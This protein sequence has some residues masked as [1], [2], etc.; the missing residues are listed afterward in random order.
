VR[1]EI[2]NPSP[3]KGATVGHQSTVESCGAASWI[4]MARGER[5]LLDAD[6]TSWLCDAIRSA[7]ATEPLAIVLT[8][9]GTTF[10]G[11]ADGPHLRETG[12]AKPFA[13]AAVELFE[14][15]D[16]IPTPVIAA[17]NGDALAGGFALA[18][19]ADIVVA[20][21]SARLGTIEASL[22]TWPMI[23]QAPALARVPA[24]AAVTNILTGVPFTALEAASLGVVDRVIE[25]AGLSAAVDGY[26]ELLAPGSTAAR[27]GRPLMRRTLN[28]NLGQS[29]RE[30]AD[31]FVAMFG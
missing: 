1:L 22:G 11:G 16:S 17:V 20:V 24:K 13:A 2:D 18:C 3:A 7:D 29:L 26:L 5:N 8:G 28:P 4:T 31:A 9:A 23:A 25:P 27:A 12:T 6:L 19:L 10:C 30:G 15:I 21:E 14:L